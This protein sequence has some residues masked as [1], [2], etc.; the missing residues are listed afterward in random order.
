MNIYKNS[1]EDFLKFSDEM[2]RNLETIPRFRNR[3]ILLSMPYVIS[4][5]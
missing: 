3:Q 1:L 5:Y 4:A 2:L